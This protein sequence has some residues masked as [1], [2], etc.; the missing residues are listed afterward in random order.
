M[1]RYPA[2]TFNF[3]RFRNLNSNVKV[4]L[5]YTSLH[6]DGRRFFR[7]K[8]ISIFSNRDCRIYNNA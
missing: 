2:T 8:E 1:N 6:G 7:N 5:L 3:F 4:Y